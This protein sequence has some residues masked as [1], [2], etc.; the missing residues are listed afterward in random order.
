MGKIND[1]QDFIV[2]AAEANLHQLIYKTIYGGSSGCTINVNGTTVQMGKESSI[3][4]AVTSVSGGTGCFLA[5][6]RPYAQGDGIQYKYVP[7][8]FVSYWETSRTSTGSSTATQVRLPLISTGSYDF[9]VEWG[10]GTSDRITVWNQAQATHTYTTAGIYQITITGRLHGFRFAN[11]GDRLKILEI[12]KWGTGFRLGGVGQYFD[13]CSN[14]NLS[15]V[16]DVLDLTGITSFSN[17]FRNCVRLSV[18]NRMNEWKVGNI[19]SLVNT[20]IDCPNFNTYIGDWD[21]S[22][23]TN[24]SATF[25]LVS[26]PGKFNQNIGNWNTSKVTL[27]NNM[28]RNQIEFNQDISTKVVTVGSNTYTAWDTLNVTNM[29]FMFSCT[30]GNLGKFNQNIGN[31][32]TSKVT[33]TRTMFQRQGF[34]NQNISTKVVTVGSNTYTAWDTFNVTDMSFMFNATSQKIVSNFNQNI[35]NWNTSKVTLMNAMFQEQSN[36]N[37]DISTKIVTVGS[38]TYTAWDTLNVTNMSAMFSNTI[39]IGKFNQNIGNWNTSKVTIMTALFQRQPIFNQDISTKVVTVGDS[40]Y[41]AWDTLNVTTMGSM[42]FIPSPFSGSFNQNISN[43]NTSK[44]TTVN[45]MFGNQT[46]FN[47]D[48]SNWNFSSLINLGYMFYISDEYKGN[49]NNN[50][51]NLINSWDTSKV[52]NM[53]GVF[54]NQTAFNQPIDDW[55]VSLVTSFNSG[56]SFGFMQGKTFEDYSSTNYDALLIGWSSRPVQPNLSINFGTIKHT[57]AAVAAKAILTSAPNNWTIIDGG[58]E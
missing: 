14:L 39:D 56:D 33:T 1:V 54:Q 24:M 31:W 53:Q 52:T 37:Q 5:G 28:F 6:N 47:Q 9:R 32:N 2:P 4:I 17:A 7:N 34:F 8:T 22:E 57:S 23:V 55:N 11:T 42:F 35:G 25:A 43:W 12:L 21:T 29:S 26:S 51:S 45:S 49:Y 18:V 48:L 46:K 10:D 3:D 44:V 20:F 40:T 16:E 27:M 36:F 15:N 30:S 38:N 50:G 19:T 41:T 58:L 13:G